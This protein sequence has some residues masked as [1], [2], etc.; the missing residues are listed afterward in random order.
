MKMNA[1]DLVA[2]VLVVVGGLNWG[3]VGWFQYNLVDSLFGVDSMLA[4]VIYG[5]VGLAAVYLVFSF[6]KKSKTV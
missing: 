2:F 4:R 5:L 3:L 6:W 1:V